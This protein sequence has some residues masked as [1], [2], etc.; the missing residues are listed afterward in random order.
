MIVNTNGIYYLEPVGANS[1]TWFWG[2]D[3]TSGDLYESEELHQAGQIVKGN[4][5]IFVHYPDGQ[6]IEPIHTDEGQYL[7]RPT[8]YREDKIYQLLVDF[9]KKEINVLCFNPDDILNG[10]K[11]ETVEKLPLSIVEDCYN[12]MLHTQPL[13]LTRQSKNHFQLLWM[14]TK[15]KMNIDFPI[16]ECESFVYMK[17]EKL[18]FSAWW[19]KE[20][21]EYEY[22][23]EYIVRNYK[24]EVIEKGDGGIFEIYPGQ[25]WNLK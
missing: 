21:P 11:V 25:Y 12:L 20:E 15:G 19:E 9:H 6:Q 16:N 3:Y 10:V 23:E 24:G 8:F 13:I 2:M 14:E 5:C 4:R 22:H 1:R 18:Y 17:D 7:G